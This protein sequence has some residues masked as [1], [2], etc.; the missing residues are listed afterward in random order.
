MWADGRQVA[1]SRTLL[2]EP[3]PIS[4]D[5]ICSLREDAPE[6]VVLTSPGMQVLVLYL[7]LC[8]L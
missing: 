6:I 4:G 5:Y 1:E 3:I 2:F 8:R 7:L